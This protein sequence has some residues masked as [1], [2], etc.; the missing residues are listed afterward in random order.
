MQ[1]SEKNSHFR[2][3]LIHSSS[4]Y[5]KQHAHNPVF[6]Y[7][8]GEEAL[9]RA[10]NEDKPILLSIG[11]STCYWCHVMEREVFM[12]P[13]IAAL[14]NEH[15]INIKVDRE[16]H[17][18]L[19]EIYMVARQLMTR[20]GGWPNNVF[21]TPELKP[22]F[23]GGTFPPADVPGRSGFPRLLEWINYTWKEQRAELNKNAEDVTEALQ[24]YLQFKPTERMA[25][26]VPHIA[27]QLFSSL[28][29]H[30]DE[31]AGGFFQAPKFPQ[32][33]Y[34]SFLASYY[35][36]THEKKALD[37]LTLSLRKM[38][39]GGIY[40]HVGCGFHRYAVDKEWYVPHFEKMLYNQAQLAR[41]YTDAARIT[42]NPWLADI[43][44]SILDFVTGPMTDGGGAFYAA[45][46]AETDGVEGAYYAWSAQ[47]LR[48]LLLPEEENFLISFYALADIPKFPGH[49][50]VEGQALIARQPLDSA[51]Q[52]KNMPYAQLAAMTGHIMNKLLNVR[53]ARRAPNLDNKI[54]VAWN[55]LMIDAFAHASKVFDK[56]HYATAA[57][58]A[59]DFLLEHAIDNEGKLRRV[60]TDGQ[61]MFAATLEDYACLIKGLLSLY[62]VS[63][64]Q[65][66]LDAAISLTQRVEELFS[67]KDGGYYFT[68]P[69]KD[70]LVRIKSPDDGALPNANALML[71]NLVELHALTDNTNYKKRAIAVRDCFLSDH[72]RMLPEMAALIQASLK[73]ETPRV[74]PLA[75][76][77]SSPEE[78]I[79]LPGVEHVIVS[80]TRE[81]NAIVV[82]F[83]I[84]GGWHINA[85]PASHAMLVPTQVDVQ[86]PGVEVVEIVYPEPL[87]QDGTDIYIGRV[88]VTVRLKILDMGQQLK[89]RVRYQP[90]SGSICHSVQDIVI[91]L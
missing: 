15:F 26:D 38:A 4:P 64:D 60:V 71:H 17:P 72:K 67:D 57:R 48:A 33:N 52:E 91:T 20:E 59:A 16:E 30:H 78:E 12:N 66:L 8:W 79:E 76:T 3:A 6:W 73:L 7:P 37:M 14:M 90:C 63:R 68:E 86:G 83:D 56:P 65:P 80:A 24:K 22:F 46:D 89:V 58:R 70:F 18:Q 29:Q 43:A 75:E 2:N 34:L 28:K 69:F 77:Y 51:A 41:V 74:G 55:G 1:A 84:E 49:K 5:L 19:D 62:Q 35:E 40:D 45:I 36:F 54:I 31:S 50:H 85:N 10:R 11:Y 82:H 88:N 21:L 81:N 23:A 44:K 9:T 39:A 87:S 42:G 47:E 27:A 61:G 53:N 32:E 13:S 25:G